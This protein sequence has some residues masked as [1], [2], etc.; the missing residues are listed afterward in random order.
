M[1]HG[2]LP[3]QTRPNQKQSLASLKG[4]YNWPHVHIAKVLKI[5]V[6]PIFGFWIVF[7][8]WASFTDIPLSYSLS[9]CT[10]LTPSHGVMM[11]HWLC[12]ISAAL[13][14]QT[15]NFHYVI[16]LSK[17]RNFSIKTSLYS[18]LAFLWVICFA[19]TENKVRDLWNHPTLH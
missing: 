19:S 11:P 2:K 13:T 1:K 17:V 6:Q 18:L 8:L 12:M 3:K 4:Q 7:F 9:W 15:N 10:Q 5:R 14:P 16:F